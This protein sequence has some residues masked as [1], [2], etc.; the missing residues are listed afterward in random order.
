M[1]RGVC[2]VILIGNAG[3]DGVVRYTPRGKAVLRISL[4]T[5]T[6]GNKSADWHRV[7]VVGDLAADRENSVSKGDLI[8]VQGTLRTR[9]EQIKG[10]S[11]RV[12][13]VIV[14]GEDTFAVYHKTSPARPVA[15][16]Q[17]AP[18]NRPAPAPTTRSDVS[19]SKSPP[20]PSHDVKRAMPVED[21]EWLSFEGLTLNDHAD[22]FR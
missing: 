5:P 13:E 7:V 21:D 6:S 12:T 19:S 10:A 1:L 16:A 8:H 11:R 9:T 17:P 3:E 14:E 4:A 15:P 18:T 22:P 20:A 2:K